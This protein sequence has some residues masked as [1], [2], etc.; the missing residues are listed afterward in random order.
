MN[1]AQH[2]AMVKAAAK[3]KFRGKQALSSKYAPHYPYSAEREYKRI[4]TAYVRLLNSELK[5]SLPS[6]MRLYSRT[7]Q[8]K[9]RF[10]DAANL[11]SETEKEF[12]KMTANLE[13]KLARFELENLIEK[14]GKSTKNA[15][16]REWKQ[17]IKTTLGI[18]LMDDYYNGEFYALMLKQWADENVQRIKSIPYEALGELE[19]LIYESYSNG[20]SV[21]K[22]QEA[23]QSKYNV[24][25]QHAQAIARDQ[26][27]SLNASVTKAQQTDAG[28]K[29][30]KWSTSKDGRVR[31]CHK[32]L[33]GKIF[34]WDNPPEM[35][36][37][38]KLHGK[39]MTGRRCHPGEDIGCRC[40]AIP[41]FDYETIDVPFD[42]GNEEK[43]GL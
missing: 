3:D 13:K 2:S 21:R 22:L 5:K 9:V 28:I 17:I 12:Q 6:L 8:D 37:K 26:I 27:A 29:R 16:Y 42:N 10:D 4:V 7:L 20:T 32:E 23:I 38:S 14:I 41:I 30:Y 18:N 40:V 34:R 11:R 31:D 24:T 15:A 19:S 25:K 39:I 33:D 43:G 35:W 1:H 36:Y